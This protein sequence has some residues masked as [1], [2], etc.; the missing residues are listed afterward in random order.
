MPK[1]KRKQKAKQVAPEDSNSDESFLDEAGSEELHEAT[2]E[3]A[4]SEQAFEGATSSTSTAG[5]RPVI[6]APP[7]IPVYQEAAGDQ[8]QLVQLFQRMITIHKEEAERSREEARSYREDLRRET[9]HNRELMQKI[10]ANIGCA[11]RGSNKNLF[12]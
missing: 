7:E 6:A 5:V 8:S 3:E 4:S 10:V 12:R 2:S 1:G 11:R 9:E